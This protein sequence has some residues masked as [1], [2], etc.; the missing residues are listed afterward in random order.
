MKNLKNIKL[1]PFLFFLGIIATSCVQDDDYNIPEINLEEPNINVNSS[2]GAVKAIYGGFEPKIV[3]AGDGSQTEMF[4]E[5]YVV[6]SDESGNYYKQLIIQDKPE[7]PTAGISISTNAT[8]LYTKYEPGRKIYFRVDGLYIGLYA[9]LPTL[10]TQNGDEIGRME[11][12]D[13]E[14]RIYRSLESVDLVPKVISITEAQIAPDNDPYLNPYLSTLIQF[15]DVQ[16]PN[17][18]AGVESYGNLNNTFGVNRNVENC[19]GNSIILRTSGFADFKNLTLPEGNGSLTAILSVFNDDFQVFIRDTNDVDMTG[20]RCGNGGP[21]DALELPFTQD[22]ESQNSGTGAS[23]NIAGWTNVNVNGGTRQWEVRAFDNNQY[24]Q[25]SA[26]NSNE[27]PYEVWLVTPGLILPSGSSPTLSFETND[28]FNNGAALTVKVSTDF[29]GDVTTATWTNLSATIS[30]GNSSGYGDEF[31]PSGDVDLSA[32]AG[33]VVYI[34][35]QY[36]GASNGTTT[37][38]QIDNVSVVE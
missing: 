34:A 6:S 37:T 18:V 16:F 33:Q 29:T 27:N 4:I 12:E 13:F 24:A 3:E 21:I 32:Y 19:E 11:I 22:F 30:S 28:G 25:T 36:E 15:Q 9:G 26:Y 5:G 31:T 17:G 1:L 2:I 14:S 8:D 38:Y 23:V 35:Y 10:G 20:E 7:N